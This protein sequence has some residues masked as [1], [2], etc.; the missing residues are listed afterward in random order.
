MK[1]HSKRVAFLLNVS[2]R[3]ERIRTSDLTVPN[4]VR[5]KIVTIAPF[6]VAAFGGFLRILKGTTPFTIALQRVVMQSGHKMDTWA[7][8]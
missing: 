7:L 3:G 8:S 1:G 6:Q 4:P 5:S 2:G